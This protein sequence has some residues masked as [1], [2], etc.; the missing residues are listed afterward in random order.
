VNSQEAKKILLLYRPAVDRDD[1][2]FAEAIALAKT[3]PELDS[4]FQQHCAFQSAASSAFNNIPV[5]D[6]LKEQILSERKAHLTLISRRRALVA[7]CAVVVIAVCG[8]LTFRSIVPPRP[9]LDYSFGNFHTNM[10]AKIIRYPEKM[11]IY[12][13]DLQAIRAKLAEL[14]QS[15][16]VFTPDVDKIVQR[17][18]IAGTGGKALDWQDK[19]VAM[20]CLNS[21]KKD[22]PKSGDLFLFIVDK[23]AVK[24]PLPGPT[25]VIT[26]DRKNI[27]SSSWTSGDK[28][29]ILAG[30]GDEAFIKPF[31][32]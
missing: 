19:Q 23:T 32:N 2:D 11:D 28:T 31:L 8:F 26:Q 27:V 24:G 30:L 25:P 22:V 15:S 17:T 12:T 5:P 4:W 29:Y 1:A 10:I 18:N 14:G 7:A 3:D 16:L 20:I 9:N 21:G 6:G 13:N